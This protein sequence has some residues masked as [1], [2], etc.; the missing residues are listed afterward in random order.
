MK[1][2]TYSLLLSVLILYGFQGFSQN[3]GPNLALGQPTSQS[4]VGWG[5][6]PEKAV[7]GNT[8]GFFDNDNLPNNSVTHT[9]DGDYDA[10]WRVDLG[11]LYD[12]SQIRIYNRTDELERLAGAEV[13]VGNINSQDVDD[14][15]LVGILNSRTIQVVSIDLGIA[16]YIMIRQ[17]D[18]LSLAEVEVYANPLNCPPAGSSCDDGD[19]NTINDEQDGDC[20]CLGTVILCEDLSIAYQINSDQRVDGVTEVTVAAG[21]DIGLFLN[22]EGVDYTVTDPSDTVLNSPIISDISSEQSGLYT[23]T[24]DLHPIVHFVDSAEFLTENGRASNAVDDDPNTIWHTEWSAIDDPYPHEI[25][26]DL[27]TESVVSGLD[28]LPR[29]DG[30]LH[31]MIAEYEIYVSNSTTNWGSPVASAHND[32]TGTNVPWAYNAD[33][34]TVAFTETQGRYVRF[35]ALSEGG[36]NDWASA[37][38]ITVISEPITPCVKTIQINVGTAYVYDGMSW[39][40]SDPNIGSVGIHDSILID[41]GD[42]EI[43]NDISCYSVT[44]APGAGL[45]INNGVTLTA[46]R[47][48]LQSTSL[49]YS[50]LIL[51][52]EINGP[53]NY[54]RHVNVIGNSAGGG[55]DLISAPVINQTFGF[56]ASEPA[57]N[58]LAASGTLRAFAPYNTAAGAYQNYDVNTNASTIIASG[59]GFRAA[60]AEGSN[61]TFTGLV[62]KSNVQVA[63]SDA[64]AGRA[65]NLIGNPYPSYLDVESF[66]TANNVNQLEDE[67]VAVYGYT[68][69]RDSWEIYNQA[70]VPSGTLMAPGQGFFVKAKSG[71]GSIIFTPAMR[72]TGTT[73]DFISGRPGGNSKALSKLNL[74]SAS[75]TAST[76]IYF[77]E[78]TTRGLDR[79]Y[80]AAAYSATK[81]DFSMFTNLLEDHT[82][83]D[84]AIQSLP[85]NDFKNVIVPLGVKAKKGSELTISIDDASTL[86]PNI[87]VYLEDTKT[88]TLTLLNNGDFKYTPTTDVNGS[89]RFNVHYSSR[90]LSIDD[91]ESNDNL[92]IFTTASPK[93]LYIVGQLTNS[94][95]AYLYDIQGRR[96][97]SKVLNANSTENTMD[98]STLSPGVYVVKIN[99]DHQTKTQRVIIR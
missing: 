74:S 54:E 43:S 92:R 71:A 6:N 86:P 28:Y 68:G 63:M 72:R 89:G 17:D 15:R 85:Y 10:W 40:P 69:S 25:V 22:L 24:S 4:S 5:G 37:A 52:G 20:N 97:L 76:S 48:I 7:D 55:N 16:R 36:D 60:T 42:A 59:V 67:Y 80:D 94:T 64:S 27:R 8:S 79:G 62:S 98:I 83:L 96:V 33:L 56:F 49:T 14:Y 77:I 13:Y 88:K 61:L 29:Q 45:T 99:N 35:V 11:E 50:S 41:S 30:I 47:T 39:L 53:V 19:P 2:S 1:N 38:E 82:G 91:I 21:D 18:I 12:L 46:N 57:N 32:N 26:I 58:S 31:G 34:K 81:V 65:W 51:N 90:T 73:D 44:I 95:I 75:N 93:S 3:L 66:F 9:A 78:G 70:N 23:V 87:N 84:I